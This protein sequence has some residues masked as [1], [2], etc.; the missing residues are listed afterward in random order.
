MDMMIEMYHYGKQSVKGIEHDTSGV[1]IK[2]GD[3]NKGGTK[4]GAALIE[5][6]KTASDIRTNSLIAMGILDENGSMDNP[7]IEINSGSDVATS[8][9][10]KADYVFIDGNVL[11]NGSPINNT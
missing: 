1:R 9:H 7:F 2:L 4:V 3:I 8:A 11:V 5:M 10:I 6:S